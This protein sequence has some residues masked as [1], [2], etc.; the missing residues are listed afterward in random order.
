[1][2]A[3]NR[4]GTARSGLA[5][6]YV[7]RKKN[8][9]LISKAA[10]HPAVSKITADT[11]GIIVYQEHVIKIFTEV[12]G[13]APGTAD[14]LRK[15]IAKKFGDEAL[16][17]EREAFIEG[18]M[19]R[20]G[21]TRKQAAKIMD[22]ITFFGSYG[23][24]KSHATAYGMIAYWC[25]YMKVHYPL[26]F[27]RALLYCEPRHERIQAVAKDSK[28]H[29]IAI[30][31]PDVSVSKDGFTIDDAKGAIRGSLVDIKG[32]GVAAAKSIM[33]NQPYADIWDFLERVE[34]RKVH[35]GVVTALSL[36][37]ALD[38][39]LP[40]TKW[41]IENIETIWKV[42]GKKT[43]IDD[44]K[45]L[46]RRSEKLPDY[47]EEERGLIASKVSP[48]A[49]GKHPIDAYADFI[50]R[51]VKVKLHPMGG[52][53]FWETHDGSDI[54]GFW[55]SGIIIEVRLNQV[56]DFHSGDPPD[57]DDK[58]RMGWGKQYANINV[59]GSDGKQRRIKID[60]DIFDSYR[61]IVIDRGKGTP[62]IVHVTGNSQF[63][64]L[65]AHI[66]IDLEEYR[67]RVNAKQ[68][69]EYWETVISG[70][71]PLRSYPFK[72]RR[73]KEHA[74][75]PLEELRQEA[76][77]AAKTAGK[78]E[79]V[80]FRVVGVITHVREKPDKNMHKMGFFGILAQD[81]YIDAMVFGSAWPHLK[82]WVKPR[83]LISIELEYSRGQGIY[84]NGPVKILK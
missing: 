37:G 6:H 49:F 42:K 3:L 63:E 60:W 40:N 9:K 74:K 50:E 48:L 76:R 33:D 65:R 19:K 61:Q 17:K 41:F 62:I 53:D 82:K 12:A 70:K 72:N 11:L 56:G 78:Y 34:A 77:A 71:H 5:G 2:T 31:P 84:N 28:K 8:P 18:A 29:G 75:I 27:F 79:R 16:A 81:G 46:V 35:R 68:P 54:A 20:T 26:E 39:L 67:K 21:M 57:E 25:M 23:F 22:A 44:L 38:T 14:S 10:F 47:D 43:K 73:L 15:K 7:A 51:N 4:P 30:L 32:V 45:A 66:V 80:S 55:V 64:S 69:L 24:N 52:D 1:M 59:E 83:E 13:F 58:L 36:A